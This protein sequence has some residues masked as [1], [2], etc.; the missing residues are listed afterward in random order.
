MSHTTDRAVCSEAPSIHTVLQGCPYIQT[1]SVQTLTVVTSS[2]VDNITL[3]YRY[4][5]DNVSFEV[6]NAALTLSD[7]YGYDEDRVISY[8]NVVELNENESVL[9]AACMLSGVLVLLD[10]SEPWNMQKLSTYSMTK[11]HDVVYFNYADVGASFGEVVFLVSYTPHNTFHVVNVSDPR[12]P[13]YL[14]GFSDS[15]YLSTGMYSDVYVNRSGHV[16]VATVGLEGDNGSGA[17]ILTDVSDPHAI[18]RVANYSLRPH[19]GNHSPW[20]PY[21]DKNGREYVY[22][23]KNNN[24][25][26]TNYS[27]TL[28]NI[29][30]A[31]HPLYV[32]YYNRPTYDIL[33]PRWCQVGDM[34]YSVNQNVVEGQPL[35]SVHIANCS[36]P[37]QWRFISETDVDMNGAMDVSSDGQ[38]MIGDSYGGNNQNLKAVFVGNPYAVRVAGVTPDNPLYYGSHSFVL[39]A[40]KSVLYGCTYINPQ[41]YQ[42]N[43]HSTNISYYTVSQPWVP[44]DDATNPDTSAP[45][46]WKFPFP[47][48][49]GYYEFYSRGTHQG[50]LEDE[51]DTPELR[52]YYYETTQQQHEYPSNGSRFVTVPPCLQVTVNDTLADTVDVYWF[53]NASGEMTL[54]ARNESVQVPQTVTQINTNMSEPKT[55]YWWRVCVQGSIWVNRTYYYTA[56]YVNHPPVLQLL[57]SPTTGHQHEAVTFLVSGMDEDSEP[58]QCFVDWG[59]GT[60]SMT[61]FFA[62]GTPVE[63]VHTWSFA[64]C[65]PVVILASD[66]RSSSPASDS[67]M[68]I[69]SIYVGPYGYLSDS[70]G[71]SWYDI[72]FSNSSG[73]LKEISHDDTTYFIDTD[74]DEVVDLI[75]D[76]VT[77]EY[78]LAAAS[79]GILQDYYP[80]FITLGI[81][82]V[83]TL[84]VYSRKKSKK[85]D[86]RK[87]VDEHRR[88]RKK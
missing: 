4:S 10:V 80:L 85:D 71:N 54:F 60:T 33:C 52:L 75:Y 65:Y 15:R 27:V 1:S 84:Y 29:S 48:G 62:A 59:D 31:R 64:D 5:P 74:G 41:E 61:D 22:L 40:N 11:I 63:L 53:S 45:W 13:V 42:F 55:M 56:D 3:Y 82:I 25:G 9:Y 68:L 50:A 34:M 88:K 77:N 7:S 72:F 81:V 28:L 67:V 30:D 70:N 37:A 66:S 8:P 21:F 86:D 19:P 12:H 43:V 14:D 57:S 76:A 23:P 79:P 44:W 32:G 73:K 36:D 83:F 2:A 49:T 46:T 24:A 87:H 78:F 51:P 26:G 17:V 16:I 35:Y 6:T 20:F 47:N 38:F 58:L 39:N 69:D 18:Q